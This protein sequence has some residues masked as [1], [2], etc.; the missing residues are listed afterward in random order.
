MDLITPAIGLVF[1]TS[2]TFL[3][4]LVILKKVAWK[5]ILNAVKE[6]EES[7]E[8][9]LQAADKAKQEM[10]SLQASNEAL[11]KEAREERD[12]LLKEAKDVRDNLIA[13]AKVKAKEEADKIMSSARESIE[14]EKNAAMAEIRNQVAELSLAVAEKILRE[15]LS[16]DEK[17]KDLVNKYIDEI[18]L[19]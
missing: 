4:L 11:L 14:T 1:W 19:N 6:R 8:N 17:Q 15:N 13:E 7:I 12:N 16:S 3:I 10:A 2:L 5:P 18:N 9:A